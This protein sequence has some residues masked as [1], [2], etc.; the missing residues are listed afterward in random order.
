MLDAALS[1][2]ILEACSLAPAVT[3]SDELASSA[4]INSMMLVHGRQHL[5]NVAKR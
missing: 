4:Y 5:T 1:T 2:V 3:T